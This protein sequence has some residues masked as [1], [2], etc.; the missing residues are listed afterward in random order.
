MHASELWWLKTQSVLQANILTWIGSAKNPAID[1]ATHVF[2][3]SLNCSIYCS[4]AWQQSANNKQSAV[5][6]DGK[7]ASRRVGKNTGKKANRMSKLTGLPHSAVNR[8]C[9]YRFR[10]GE[11]S[12]RMTCTLAQ[13]HYG[14]HKGVSKPLRLLRDGEGMPRSAIESGVEHCFTQGYLSSHLD[15]LDSN[16]IGVWI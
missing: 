6:G 7:M 10:K 15:R 8:M 4:L 3:V 2:R 5:F 12:G 9:G 16:V 14:G 1:L 11:C 13:A